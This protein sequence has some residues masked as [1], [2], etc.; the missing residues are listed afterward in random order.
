MFARVLTFNDASV[1]S[2]YNEVLARNP[3][4]PTLS[5]SAFDFVTNVEVVDNHS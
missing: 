2:I 3:A 1:P 5:V 4:P